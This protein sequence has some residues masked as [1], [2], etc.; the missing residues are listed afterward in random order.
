MMR[1]FRFLFIVIMVGAPNCYGQKCATEAKVIDS[2]EAYLK[3]IAEDP[4]K[5]LVALKR[6]IPELVVDMRYATVYNFTHKILYDRP[7]AYLQEG[8]AYAL[9]DVQ[10]EFKKKGLALKV[11]DAF[12]SFSVTCK[13]WRLVS[14]R[15]YA[16]NP[17]KG[18]NHNRG[19]AVD[20][21]LIDL[22]TGKELDMGTGF[23]NF[24]DSAHH[25]FALLPPQ[26]LANRRLLKSTM[27][28]HGFGHV[29]TEWWHY[30]WRKDRDREIIDMEFDELRGLVK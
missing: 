25:D 7:V 22:K 6:V 9:K 14:D 24:T 2:K 26:V 19:L 30:Q 23:D 3:A 11:Y 29:P 18:S 12:R 8:P 1:V 28:R 5:K 27:S 21:T 4:A 20:I 16:A 10:E 13:I 17:R 15:H